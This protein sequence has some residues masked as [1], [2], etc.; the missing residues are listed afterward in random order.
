ML[1]HPV[2][3]FLR[4]IIAMHSISI[5][6]SPS[7]TFE[8]QTRAC[9]SSRRVIVV[10]LQCSG[11]ALAVYHLV[12]HTPRPRHQDTLKGPGPSVLASFDTTG[13]ATGHRCHLLRDRE[14]SRLH[15]ASSA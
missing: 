15:G 5:N 13:F 10:R 3:W 12:G 7:S 6:A 8:A 11:R 1:S 9:H 4:R 2:P 14:L